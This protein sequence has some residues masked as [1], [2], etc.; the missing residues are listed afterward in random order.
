VKST[1][2]SKT[3]SL[4]ANF[5]VDPR[6]AAILGENYTSSERALRELVDNAWDAE[7][8]VVKITLPEIL[9]DAPITVTNDGSGMKEQE[10]RQE[11]LNIASPRYSRKGEKTPNLQRTVKGRREVGKFAGLILAG[12]ME[13]DTKA[14]GARTRLVI[15]KSALL[16]AQKDIEQVPL[17]I[18]VKPCKPND[19]STTITLK[20]LNQNLNYPKAEKLR[21]ILAY[22]YGRE[23][24]F[25]VFIN[26]ERVLRHDIQGTT[27]TKE[28]TLLNG[29]KATANY[30]ISEK[31]VPSRKAGL[32]LRAGEK[33]VGKPHLWGLEHDETLSDRLRSRIVGEVKVEAG[34]IELTAAGGDVIESDKG[35]EQLTQAVQEELLRG[36]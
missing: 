25:E 3:N 30:T 13:V 1:S 32:I 29:T 11:Y 28:Y 23:T 19:H 34:A 31:P 26:G 15:S 9:S 10:L 2:P 8:K 24:G 7:A 12:R 21:E 4:T 18:D 6:L 22:D 14:H 20:D 35:L 16:S 36:L 33:T 5:S 27:F 17:P